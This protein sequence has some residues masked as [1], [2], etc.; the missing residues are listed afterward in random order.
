[1]G[2]GSSIGMSLVKTIADLE[3]AVEK[4]FQY[5]DSLI[6]EAYVKGVEL[7]GSVIGNQDLLALPI[8]EIIPNKN[9]AFFEYDAKYQKGETTEI[10]PAR[11]SDKLAEKAKELSKAAHRMLYCEG[12]SRTDM[13]CH[14]NDIYVLETNTIPG[15]TQTSLLPLAAKT[16]GINFSELLDRLIRLGLDAH[17]KRKKGEK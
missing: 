6:L 2:L 13:I 5:D 17:D 15:M 11:I 16:A 3:A 4:A 12:Y 1:V 10:C 8:I 7:T 9:Y 14:E